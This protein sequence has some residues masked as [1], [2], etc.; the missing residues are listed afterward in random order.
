MPATSQC[1]TRAGRSA[2]T[3]ASPKTECSRAMGAV[4]FHR[5]LFQTAKP[6]SKLLSS[7]HPSSKLSYC[8]IFTVP[9]KMGL[10]AK[11]RQELGISLCHASRPQTKNANLA[12]AARCQNQEPSSVTTPTTCAP[13]ANLKPPCARRRKLGATSLHQTQ[14]AK[15]KQIPAHKSQPCATPSSENLPLEPHTLN[16]A[17]PEE[18]LTDS[19]LLRVLTRHQGAPLRLRSKERSALKALRK[20]QRLSLAA[21]RAT[22]C[23]C[24]PLQVKRPPLAP[25]RV[26]KPRLLMLNHSEI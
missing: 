7:Y 6:H 15:L 4:K 11:C 19:P 12:V 23:R 5:A 25:K 17:S 8:P 24:E 14:K 26:A 13:H 16:Q 18:L 2:R 1:S 22:P 10:S 20:A 3:E 21:P 9:D